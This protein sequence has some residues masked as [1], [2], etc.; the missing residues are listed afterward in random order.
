MGKE[1]LTPGG[2]EIEK[3]KFFFTSIKVLFFK[4]M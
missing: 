4:K 1:T 2:I 3:K